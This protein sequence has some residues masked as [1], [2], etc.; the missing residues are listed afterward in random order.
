MLDI[1]THNESLSLMLKEC[2]N[3]HLCYVEGQVTKAYER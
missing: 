1:G 3:I 2:Q